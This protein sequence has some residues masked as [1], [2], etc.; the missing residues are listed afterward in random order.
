MNKSDL[1]AA[2]RA[3]RREV[4]EHIQASGKQISDALFGKQLGDAQIKVLEQ[5]EDMGWRS[6][7]AERM[8]YMAQVHILFFYCGFSFRL[9]TW[10][11][12]C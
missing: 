12:S 4:L 1:S 5:V 10:C 7:R 2:T 11:S 6:L 9:S 8:H 3:R